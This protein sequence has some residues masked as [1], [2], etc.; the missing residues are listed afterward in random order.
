MKAKEIYQR[1]PHLWPRWLSEE[2]QERLIKA[3]AQGENARRDSIIIAAM[4]YLG[5]SPEDAVMVRYCTANGDAVENRHWKAF[6]HIPNEYRRMI[7][8]AIGEA[9]TV[10]LT[11]RLTDCR[12]KDAEAVVNQVFSRA[13][14]VTDN[15]VMRLQR[16]AARLHYVNGWTWEGD[17]K[18]WFPDIDYIPGRN[19]VLYYRTKTDEEEQAEIDAAIMRMPAALCGIEE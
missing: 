14:L 7:R 5:M 12:Q 18:R 15:S 9:V 13:G 8:G 6:L 11:E 16:T 19:K 2:E 1:E 10:Q 3:A 4:L 17:I